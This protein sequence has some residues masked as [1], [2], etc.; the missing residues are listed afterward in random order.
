VKISFSFIEVKLYSKEGGLKFQT[1][2]SPTNGY[3]MVPIYD[4]GE[5]VLRIEAPAG[6]NFEPQSLDLNIDGKTDKCSRFEDIN[7]HFTGFTI[8]GHVVSKGQSTGPAGV[9]LSLTLVEKSAVLQKTNSIENGS[10]SFKNILPGDFVIDAVHPTWMFET[11]RAVAKVTSDTLDVG[12]IITIL[13]Y[14]IKGQV[15]SHDD[16]PISGVSFHLM[17]SNTQMHRLSNCGMKDQSTAVTVNEYKEICQVESS[18]SGWFTFA[19]VPCGS[20]KLIPSYK[21]DNVKFDVIPEKL[22]VVVEHDSVILKDSFR[23]AGFTVSGYVRSS[24]LGAGVANAKVWI[25]GL[26]ETSTNGDGLYY[27]EQMTAGTYKLNVAAPHITFPSTTLKITSSTSQLPDIVASK[28]AVC[29][30]IS[31]ER[32]P[33][34]LHAE[35]TIDVTVVAVKVSGEKYTSTQTKAGGYFCIDCEPGTY[36][37]SV[38]LNEVIQ[39]AGLKLAPDQKN[40]IVVDKPIDNIKFSQFYAKV[41]GSVMCLGR[42]AYNMQLTLVDMRASEESKT[43]E[44]QETNQKVVRFLFN[45]IMP[46]NYIMSITNV[47]WCWSASSVEIE[48]IDSD[49]LD[50]IFS[51]SGY[52]VT[53]T[54]SHS[55]TLNVHS[56]D[57]KLIKSLK[58]SKGTNKFCLDHSGLYHFH[59]VSCHRFE[60]EVYEYDTSQPGIL[61]LNAVGHLVEGVVSSPIQYPHLIISVKSSSSS[62]EIQIVNMKESSVNKSVL[63]DESKQDKNKMDTPFIHK[64]TYSARTGDKLIFTASSNQLLFSPDYVET[65]VHGDECPVSLVKFEGREGVF[66]TGQIHPAVDS[67]L[68]TVV[69]KDDFSKRREM[70]TTE[71]GL[72]SLGPLDAT[73]HYDVSAVKEGF[74]FTPIAGKNGHFKA[75]KLGQILIQVVDKD[76]GQSLQGALLSLSGENNFRQSSISQQHGSVLFSYL[77]P[78]EYFLKPMMKEYQFEPVSQIIE[79]LNGTAVNITIIGKRIA[80][81]CF[82]TVMSPSGEP[83]PGVYLE[84]IGVDSSSSCGQIQEESKSEQDG[85]FRLRGLQPGCEYYLR[86]KQGKINSHIERYIPMF[87]K[88]KI[89]DKNFE[90]FTI[91]VFRQ[92][93]HMDIS[94]IVLVS[95]DFLS[96]LKVHLYRESNIDSHLHSIVLSSTPFFYLP[97]IP[98]DNETYVIKLSTS[99]SRSTYNFLLQE[100]HFT[101]NLSFKHFTLTFQP[102]T[103]PSDQD[104]NHRFF[105][106]LPFAVAVLYMIYNYEQMYPLLSSLIASLQMSL[107][108]RSKSPDGTQSSKS[109]SSSSSSFHSADYL[110]D[111]R[112][113]SISEIS[114]KKLKSK[115]IQ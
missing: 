64:F 94:G 15:L 107:S 66:V 110:H 31:V 44:V 61:A 80:Y 17:T 25:D 50:I 33:E 27:L 18:L 24:A 54:L 48:I 106:V 71:T 40:V 73:R 114:K 87:D 12:S 2:C 62:E 88:I 69:D 53:L 86:V 21:G 41:G 75:V 36:S 101:A 89:T 13:G 29:G 39:K 34:G 38:K 67:V 46:G 28:F 97:T 95:Q 3:Y 112:E 35:Q 109:L 81:S 113:L 79:V 57:E 20:Y 85:S 98:M 100:I 11:S 49:L 23:V 9:T 14:D 82:G 56:R 8:N 45:D 1:D 76:S 93:N 78:G 104:V 108:N 90:D 105:L 51:Q 115:K 6:W 77:N 4:K 111:T 42:C 84:A 7:F 37:L 96:T 83:E 43:I 30:S 74:V 55:L 32:L 16:E 59:P 72:F 58:L 103:K 99:L 68:I 63:T 70:L 60:H 26:G 10:F 5:Y 65:T 91:L 52:Q 19:A 22:D 102:Q 47:D 92:I